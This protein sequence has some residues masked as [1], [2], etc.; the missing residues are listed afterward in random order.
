MG[1]LVANVPNG[2]NSSKLQL[3]EVL[4]SPE[5]GYILVS[6]GHL[7]EK[8]FSANFSSGKCSITGPDG[9]AA[10]EVL[11]L[12]QLHHCLGHISVNMAKK[13]AMDGFVTGLC[14]EV[15]TSGNDFFCESCVHAKAT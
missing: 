15:T 6:I 10:E 1:E 3:T 5:V 11:T 14:L 4:Y 8:G 13:L 7:D 9:N 12:D 2:V